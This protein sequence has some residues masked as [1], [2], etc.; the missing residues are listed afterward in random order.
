QPVIA[1]GPAS[2][3]KH[4]AG[5]FATQL[6]KQP[7]QTPEGYRLCVRQDAG[8]PV[9]LVIGNDSRGVL[10]GVG[11]LLREMHMARKSMTLDDQLDITT[12]HK[13]RVRGHQLGYRPKCNSYDAWDLPAWEQY[14]R[15]LA[16][17]GCNTVE[18]IPPRSDD[19]ADSPHFPRPQLEMMI[20]MSRLA[21]DY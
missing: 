18:L 7:H 2:Q 13:F 16:V 3:L 15:D 4:F 10:F 5:P 9:V 14:Y 6:E 11:R 8:R 1:V 21:S 20:G 17:F 19:A 12:A